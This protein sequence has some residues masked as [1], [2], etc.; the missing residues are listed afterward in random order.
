MNKLWP[1]ENLAPSVTVTSAIADRS[2][3]AVPSPSS[4]NVQAVGGEIEVEIEGVG[5]HPVTVGNP[6]AVTFVDDPATAPVRSIG[7]RIE[8]HEAFGDDVN[9][10]FVVVEAE[11]L[12]MRVW[13]RGVGETRACGTGAA[14]AVAAATSLGMSDGVAQVDL[15][16]GRLLVELV[17]GVARITGPANTV[18]T[19]QFST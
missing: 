2:H 3:V 5:Y 16:G 12:R 4:T 11:S 18:F 8:H 1:T 19:G 6:H 17:D 7:P 14:A 9:V 13:E 10:E 15:L